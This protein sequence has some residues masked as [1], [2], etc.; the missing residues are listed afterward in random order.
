[1]R[2]TRDAER[3]QAAIPDSATKAFARHGLW[4]RASTAS[5]SSNFRNAA[6]QRD[7]NMAVARLRSLL[8]VHGVAT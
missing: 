8:A 5:P 4:A 3:T 7:P 6:L 1:M 2:P